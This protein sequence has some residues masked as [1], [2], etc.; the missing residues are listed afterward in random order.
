MKIGILLEITP[1]M[2]VATLY[3]ECSRCSQPIGPYFVYE[4]HEIVEATYCDTCRS[5][6]RTR[7]NTA[8]AS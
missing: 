2:K 5:V 1:N 4:I 7:K 3:R 8:V 6:I